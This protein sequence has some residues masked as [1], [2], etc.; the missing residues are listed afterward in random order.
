MSGQESTVLVKVK[1]IHGF[2][3]Y[4]K[5]IKGKLKSGSNGMC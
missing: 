3:M 2:K 4:L 1:Q 5:H